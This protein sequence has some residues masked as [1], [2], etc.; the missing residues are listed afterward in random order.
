MIDSD[1]VVFE[2]YGD[3]LADLGRLD[4]ARESWQRALTLDPQKA[5]LQDKLNR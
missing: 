2:H 3:V 4:E 1:A 5:S